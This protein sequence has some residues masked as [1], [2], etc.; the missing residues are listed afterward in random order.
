MEILRKRSIKLLKYQ[1]ISENHE[2]ILK[3]STIIQKYREFGFGEMSINLKI[4]KKYQE[5]IK[6]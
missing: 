4:T 6:K 1:E 3:G 2:E 5:I